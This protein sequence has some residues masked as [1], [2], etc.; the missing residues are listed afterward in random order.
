MLRLAIPHPCATAQQPKKVKAKEII[1]YF[2]HLRA[3][4]LRIT[5]NRLLLTEYCLPITS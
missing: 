1:L 5:D 4:C 3:Y 2:F